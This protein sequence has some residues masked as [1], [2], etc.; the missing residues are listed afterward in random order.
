MDANLGKVRA[1][2][3]HEFGTNGIV[4]PDIRFRLFHY[5]FAVFKEDFQRHKMSQ[6]WLMHIFGISSLLWSILDATFVH[7]LINGMPSGFR[8]CIWLFSVVYCMFQ[9]LRVNQK[10][11]SDKLDNK[12][13]IIDNDRQ[14]IEN[15]I[16]QLEYEEKYVRSN[17]KR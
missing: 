10:Y 8:Y 17:G 6:W 15:K 1:I 14:L 16:K 5:I 12:R 3:E 9:A 7:D 11:I 4:L 13:K 2:S